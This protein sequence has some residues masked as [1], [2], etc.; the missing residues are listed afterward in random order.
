MPESN[1]E[2]S[3][4]LVITD[5]FSLDLLANDAVFALRMLSLDEASECVCEALYKSKWRF[6]S[7]FF[8]DWILNVLNHSHPFWN[9]FQRRAGVVDSLW[10][11]RECSVQSG[12]IVVIVS[13]PKSLNKSELT[14][15]DLTFRELTIELD[16][17]LLLGELIGAS[18]PAQLTH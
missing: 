15:G 13:R 17:Q 12:D 3:A 6:L 11:Q 10:L 4:R 9:S 5:S 8:D 1:I 7:A 16:E 2:P 14:I 18:E